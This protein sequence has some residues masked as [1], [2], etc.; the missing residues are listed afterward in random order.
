M[1]IFIN[2]ISGI[3]I[4][5]SQDEIIIMTENN[6]SEQLKKLLETMDI[7]EIETQIGYVESGRADLSQLPENIREIY[8]EIVEYMQ[9]Q[10]E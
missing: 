4:I 7:E 8:G 6:Y 10:P 2:T 5:F 9:N 3:G 1:N